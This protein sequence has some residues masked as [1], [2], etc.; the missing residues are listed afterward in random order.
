MYRE[1]TEQYKYLVK[2]YGPPSEFGYK[3]FIPK[4]KAEKFD[5]EEWAELFKKAGAQFAGPVAEHHD[6]FS[7]WDSEI[8]KWNAAKMGP[9]RDVVGE[10][11]K[12]IRKRGMKFMVAFHHAENWWYYPHWR[13][14]FDTSDPQYSGH[15]QLRSHFNVEETA[16]S[17]TYFTTFH[18]G[19]L[20][21]I[22]LKKHFHLLIYILA[23]VHALYR[24]ILFLRRRIY[25][26]IVKTTTLA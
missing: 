24:P 13:K 8:N 15:P 1:G 2:N 14:E 22:L 19:V 6:G 11:E 10:L 26:Y 25:P 20:I 12:A 16:T 21:S 9:K 18:N 5:P 3:D 23:Y 17:S 7:M 4:F